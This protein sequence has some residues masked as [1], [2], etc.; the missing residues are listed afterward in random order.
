MPYFRE[1]WDD[2]A[3]PVAVVGPQESW[4]LRRLASRCFCVDMIESPFKEDFTRKDAKAQ[5]TLTKMKVAGGGGGPPGVIFG[6][7]RK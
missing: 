6:I 2:A 5:R 1:L 4:A 7:I 3:F